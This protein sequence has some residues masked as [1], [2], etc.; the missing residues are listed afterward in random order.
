[1]SGFEKYRF[2]PSTDYPSTSDLRP[3]NQETLIV[4]SLAGNPAILSRNMALTFGRVRL[5]L[6]AL[7]R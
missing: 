5:R 2:M 4:R 6:P 3:L 1:M 7:N